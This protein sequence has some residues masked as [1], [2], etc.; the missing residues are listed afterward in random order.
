MIKIKVF[1]PILMFL[2]LFGCAPNKQLLQLDKNEIN[3]IKKMA[4]ITTI[5]NN[6]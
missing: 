4:V 3:T 1:I 2:L 5:S 6:G